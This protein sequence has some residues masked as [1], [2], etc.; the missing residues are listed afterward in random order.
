MNKRV[1]LLTESN[2]AERLRRIR[3]DNSLAN[4]A[5]VSF[6]LRAKRAVFVEYAALKHD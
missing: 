5:A 4:L 2:A 6:L 3:T 1:L